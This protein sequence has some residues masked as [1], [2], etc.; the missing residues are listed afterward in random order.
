MHTLHISVGEVFYGTHECYLSQRAVYLVG[1]INLVKTVS[2][3]NSAHLA[4]ISV[5]EV[6]YG[7]HECYPS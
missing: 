6:F 2:F 5:G 4:Y 7:T 3:L 1:E